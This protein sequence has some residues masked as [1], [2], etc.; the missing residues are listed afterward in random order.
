M[1]GKLNIAD[2]LAARKPQ[3]ALARARALQADKQHD[4]AFKLLVIAAE[5]GLTEA[6]SETSICT[7]I[8]GA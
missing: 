6:E 2:R 5:A 7:L 1:S 8:Y 3:S 4:R